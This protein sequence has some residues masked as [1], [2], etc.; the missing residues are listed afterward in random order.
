MCDVCKGSTATRAR[1]D[2]GL[3]CLDFQ[4]TQAIFERDLDEFEEP[5]PD[6]YYPNE[7]KA[8]DEDGSEDGSEGE[9]QGEKHEGFRT[10]KNEMERAQEMD[11]EGSSPRG[12]RELCDATDSEEEVPPTRRPVVPASPE[13]EDQEVE[14]VVLE[15]HREKKKTD[16]E[17]LFLP[18]SDG[19]ELPVP[20]KMPLVKPALAGGS[21]VNRTGDAGPVAPQG[22]SGLK[23]SSFLEDVAA[24]ATT[25]NPSITGLIRPKFVPPM[26]NNS[27][28]DSGQ[29][30]SSGSSTSCGGEP[31]L[32][33][34]AGP[35]SLNE[36]PIK[37]VLEPDSYEKK[38]PR[39][40]RDSAVEHFV[41]YLGQGLLSKHGKRSSA[42][43]EQVWSELGGGGS[44]HEKRFVFRSFSTSLTRSTGVRSYQQQQSG[45]SRT[46]SGLRRLPPVIDSSS[47]HD[48]R[49]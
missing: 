26:T 25:A 20:A 6:E 36:A 48:P 35:T 29:L 42:S 16:V 38:I 49:P 22:T 37:Y 28:R 41:E 17:L 11:E 8:S 9:E 19:E 32:M 2:R 46:S 10:A 24:H 13:L 3:V 31:V 40:M 7:A 12:I 14:L 33:H 5:N 15:E 43:E 39:A 23:G 4:Q 30:V 27:I 45:S 47:P 44:T 21:G 1:R 34:A 18:S